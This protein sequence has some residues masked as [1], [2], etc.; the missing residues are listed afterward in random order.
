[1]IDY[2]RY[3]CGRSKLMH[4]CPNV[5]QNNESQKDVMTIMRDCKKYINDRVLSCILVYI[6][7]MNPTIRIL[8]HIHA[9]NLVFVSYNKHLTRDQELSS[10]DDIISLGHHLSK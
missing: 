1:M 6:C 9:S 8:S 7:E 3:G 10:I 4:D 2:R 5:E